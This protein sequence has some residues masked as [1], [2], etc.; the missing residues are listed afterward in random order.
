MLKNM[1]NHSEL[2][3]FLL[4]LELEVCINTSLWGKN[5]NS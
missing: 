4:T 5:D 1:Q 2:Y 3:Y